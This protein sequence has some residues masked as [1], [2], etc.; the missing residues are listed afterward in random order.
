MLKG[1][2][3]RSELGHGSAGRLHRFEVAT[4]SREFVWRG[5]DSAGSGRQ[6]GSGYPV[7]GHL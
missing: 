5:A 2:R 4:P 7:C 3:E 1:S 6:G